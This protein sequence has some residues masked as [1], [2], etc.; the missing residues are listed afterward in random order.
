MLPATPWQLG[1]AKPVLDR[2]A[3][4][5]IDA[6]ALA[7]LESVD[8]STALRELI[9]VVLRTPESVRRIA[10]TGELAF[11]VVSAISRKH[12][13]KTVLSSLG[14]AIRTEPAEVLTP[15][16]VALDRLLLKLDL[17]SRLR[18]QKRTAAIAEVVFRATPRRALDVVVAKLDGG[19]IGT[20]A[21]YLERGMPGEVWTEGTLDEAL[22]AVPEAHFANAVVALNA[23]G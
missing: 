7:Q 18:E 8:L 23:Q 14:Q 6:W 15:R 20:L 4:R 1:S 12:D 21:R 2:K 16:M 11:D 13:A 19:R 5:Q 9:P 17:E 10:H 3:E 22:A